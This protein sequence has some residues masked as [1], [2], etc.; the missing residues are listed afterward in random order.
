MHGQ[1]ILFIT[2]VLVCCKIEKSCDKSRTFSYR[3]NVGKQGFHLLKRRWNPFCPTY[4]YC[5]VPL[6][7]VNVLPTSTEKLPVL[8]MSIIELFSVN[9][10]D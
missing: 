1:A 7:K 10:P 6:F 4:D 9:E 2:L 3:K 8:L 5:I